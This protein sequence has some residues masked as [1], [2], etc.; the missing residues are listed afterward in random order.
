MNYHETKDK[1]ESLGW[2]SLKPNGNAHRFP[3]QGQ[4]IRKSLVLLL[5][6][7]IIAGLAA[8]TNDIFTG[9]PRTDAG[10]R[11][12]PIKIPE[13]ADN[14]SRF[15]TEG[16]KDVTDLVYQAGV[17]FLSG[18]CKIT[19][20]AIEM[21]FPLLAEIRRGTANREGIADFSAFVAVTDSQNKRLTQ[22]SMPYRVTFKDANPVASIQD[23]ITITIPK[24]PDQGYQDFIVYLGLE[25]NPSELQ[26]NQKR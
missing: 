17:G 3:Q 20:N 1:R 18:T 8:C 12:P 13:G 7:G 5:I 24:R 11:C 15:R 14:Y 16:R 21:S 23:L 9:K 25:M 22:T 19:P 2:L 4:T 10:V 6:L 26:A